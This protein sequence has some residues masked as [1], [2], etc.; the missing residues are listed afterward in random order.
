MHVEGESLELDAL[1]EG[2]SDFEN[3]ETEP[4]NFLENFEDVELFDKNQPGEYHYQKSEYGK[5]A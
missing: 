1:P 2:E 5:N 4:R 3:E